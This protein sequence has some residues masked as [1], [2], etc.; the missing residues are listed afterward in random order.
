M[1]KEQ[2]KPLNVRQRKFIAEYLK[3]GNGT[4]AAIRSGYALAGA[5]VAAQRL[6]KN[7]AVSAALARY[8]EKANESAELTAAKVLADIEHTRIKALESGGYGAALKASELQGKALKMWFEN[9]TVETKHQ[10]MTDAELRARLA[11]LLG[12]QAQ[13]IG[14][15]LP[16]PEPKQ[17]SH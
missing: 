4:Q 17:L 3:D 16:D 15:G 2:S 10:G 13:D 5:H 7:A 1:G 14:D 12:A 9:H 6:L 11:E 8:S